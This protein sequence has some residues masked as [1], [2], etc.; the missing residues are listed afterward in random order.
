M[1]FTQVLPLLLY[2]LRRSFQSNG[3]DW[4]YFDPQELDDTLTCGENIE[5]VLA[6]RGLR[7]REAWR[8][9][10]RRYAPRTQKWVNGNN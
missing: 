3:V 1:K 2:N 10:Y 4:D 7:T 5:A 6:Q 9:E 8:T